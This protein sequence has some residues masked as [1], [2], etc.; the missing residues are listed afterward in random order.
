VRFWRDLET[1]LPDVPACAV[2]RAPFPG[3]PRA[4]VVRG[5]PGTV[6]RTVTVGRVTQGPGDDWLARDRTRAGRLRA[7]L[8]AE[9]RSE[10]GMVALL[11]GLVPAGAL[12][13]LGNSLPV[14]EWDLAAAR[15]PRGW[16]VV[17]SRGANGIDGQLSTFLGFC[18]PGR[19]HWAVVGDLTALYDLA[20][21]WMLRGLE[22]GPVRIVIVNNGGGQ[23]FARLSPHA[24]LRNEHQLDFADWARMWDLPYHRW[25]EVPA[26]APAEPRCVIELVPDPGATR[27]FWDAH[28]ALHAAS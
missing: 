14:R 2:S 21:P 8:A 16:Q 9:S 15:E 17:A 26:A 1:R 22:S 4:R 27:R 13:Y 20:A 7:L 25:N 3:L 11:S 10:P 28:D 6:L 12:V 24:V 5:D 23:I 19:E 18:Q